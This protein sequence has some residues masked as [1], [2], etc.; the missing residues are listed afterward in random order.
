MT[1]NVSNSIVSGTI[2]QNTEWSG[3]ITLSG[4]V[5]ISTGASLTINSGTVITVTSG[6]DIM[7]WADTGASLLVNGTD[8]SKVVFKSNSCQDGDWADGSDLCHRNRLHFVITPTP[9]N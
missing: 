9:L 4:S 6:K 8:D 5:K 7:L 2:N 1:I 3:N